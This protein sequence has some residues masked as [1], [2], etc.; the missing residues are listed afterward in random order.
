MS[1][2]SGILQLQESHCR[3]RAY[4]K[5]VCKIKSDKGKDCNYHHCGYNSRNAF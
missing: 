3:W 1:F 5:K 4:R 2:I